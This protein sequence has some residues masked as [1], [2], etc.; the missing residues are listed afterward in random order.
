MIF[1]TSSTAYGVFKSWSITT[2][3]SCIAL[4][5][6]HCFTVADYT[7]KKMSSAELPESL[8]LRNKLG[9]AEGRPAPGNCQSFAK[10]MARLRATTTDLYIPNCF[11]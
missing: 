6:N 1:I 3:D 5:D 8:S 9:A 4:N 7:G 11:R 2:T 10:S